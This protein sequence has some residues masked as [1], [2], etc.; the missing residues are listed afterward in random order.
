MQRDAI[1]YCTRRVLKQS[2]GPDYV[3]LDVSHEDL[4][5]STRVLLKLVN[6]DK[7]LWYVVGHLSSYM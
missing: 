3:V 4:S 6:V 2:A 5:L 1:G 7:V